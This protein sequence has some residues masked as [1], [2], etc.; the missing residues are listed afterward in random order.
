MTSYRRLKKEE[1]N[2]YGGLGRADADEL[3]GESL[4]ALIS[5]LSSYVN[6]YVGPLLCCGRARI[7][8]QPLEV[9]LAS[10][11]Q[12]D[13]KRTTRRVKPRYEYFYVP[14]KTAET[15]PRSFDKNKNP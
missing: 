12:T 6:V 5:R 15:I 4:F 14:V 13:R 9:P 10:V 1:T 3:E 2:K 8:Q 7:V 11:K